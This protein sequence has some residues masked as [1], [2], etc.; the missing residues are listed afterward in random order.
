M[1]E[2]SFINNKKNNNFISID[3]GSKK[4]A[5]AVFINNELREYNY[6]ETDNLEYFTNLINNYNITIVYL[7][8]VFISV[9]A[10][11]YINAF[12][13]IKSQIRLKT[14]LDDILHIDYKLIN[15]SSWLN[16]LL[17][18]SNN[19]HIKL[20]KKEKYNII[21]ELINNKYNLKLKQKDNDLVAAIGIGNFIIGK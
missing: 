20:N 10:I 12:K 15:N 8:D 13:M 4:H 17:K 2:K 18:Q 16:Y 6:F 11:K 7:E 19:N 5:Y 9:N 14:W 1:Q 3:P 21:R